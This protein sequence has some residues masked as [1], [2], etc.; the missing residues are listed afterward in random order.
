MDCYFDKIDKT[1]VEQITGLI[2]VRRALP[3]ASLGMKN[4]I[5]L[6]GLFNFVHETVLE[7]VSKLLLQQIEEFDGFVYTKY[8]AL[9][10]NE[11]IESE[12]CFEFVDI[13][14]NIYLD[15]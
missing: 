12:Q 7:E 11:K 10:L 2:L 4:K 5:C 1:E 8:D 3:N 9:T 13:M 15:S 14:V 6:F